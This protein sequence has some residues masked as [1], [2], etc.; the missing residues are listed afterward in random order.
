MSNYYELEKENRKRSKIKARRSNKICWGMVWMGISCVLC[1][2][3]LVME[4]I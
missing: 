3:S 2:L 4:A 1:V